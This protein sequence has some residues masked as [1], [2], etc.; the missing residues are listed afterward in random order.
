[1]KVLISLIL[2]AGFL[3]GCSYLNRKLGFEDDNP[4]EEAIESK[5]EDYTGFD[6]DLSPDS[7]E[8]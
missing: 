2:I 4:V 8:V 3:G 7:E 6:I 1:M 5:I